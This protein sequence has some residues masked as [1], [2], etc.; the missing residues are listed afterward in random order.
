MLALIAIVVALGRSSARVVYAAGEFAPITT[1][2]PALAFGSVAWGDFDSDGDQ[3][4]LVTGCLAFPCGNSVPFISKVFRNDGAETFTDIAA[5]LVGVYESSVAWGD[6]DRDGDL[7]ILLAGLTTIFSNSAIT[8]IYRN[9]GNGTFTDVGALLPGVGNGSVAWGDYD[10]D[11]DL[12]ILLAGHSS[13]G[14][15]TLSIYRN[16]GAAGF[17]DSG[18]ALGGVAGSAAAW[19][20]YD[21]DGDLDILS[22]GTTT[23]G[24]GGSITRIYR[25]DGNGGFAD[26]GISLP[27]VSSSAV[28]WADY[29]NDGD[30]DLV[31]CG[32]ERDTSARITRIYRNDAG[33]FTDIVAGLIGISDGAVAWGDFDND[34][35]LDL[36]L[37]GSTGAEVTRLYRNDSNHV[38][39][40]VAAGLRDVRY[41]SAAWADANNDARLDLVLMGNYNTEFDHFTKLYLNNAAAVN[42]TPSVP[43]GLAANVSGRTVT[44]N[45]NAASDAETDAPGLTYNVRVG[46]TPGGSQIMSAVADASTGYR[47][48]PQTG[49]VQLGLTAILKGLA[50]GTYYW[51]VQAVDS[52]FAGSP[53]AAEGSFMMAQ[54]ITPTIT[55]TPTSTPTSTPIPPLKLCTLVVA[56]GHLDNDLAQSGTLER[57]IGNFKKGAHSGVCITLWADGPGKNNSI[58]YTCPLRNGTCSD[59]K[60]ETWKTYTM[61]EDSTDYTAFTNFISGTIA[62]T[63]NAVRV[64]VAL[65]GHGSGWSASAFPSLP[66]PWKPQG[67]RMGGMSWDDT[68]DNEVNTPQTR[69]LSTQ[70]MADALYQV[71]RATG[72][73]IDLLYLD[74][75][76][77]G[78]IEVLYELRDS[79]HYVLASPNTDW[80]SFAYHLVL[81]ATKP[82]LDGLALGK[83]WLAQEA[84]VLNAN[85]YPHTLAVYDLSQINAVMSATLPFKAMLQQ[86]LATHRAKIITAATNV[87]RYEGNYNGSI[88]LEDV[89]V[90]FY[91]LGLALHKEFS[92]TKTWV[93]VVQT[94][95]STLKPLVA[96]SRFVTG[97]PWIYRGT[98]WNWNDSLGVSLYLPLPQ[99][100]S[101]SKRFLY[102]ADHLQ[103][104]RDTHW[105]EFLTAYWSEATQRVHPSSVDQ[106]PTC[107]YTR[108]CDLLAKQLPLPFWRVFLPVVP[109]Q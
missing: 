32:I 46:T 78:A 60:N 84:S 77:M 14:R 53:F 52:G 21:G 45:W 83:A 97:T 59:D 54:P 63:P 96:A 107:F 30:L 95:T 36:V 92:D 28:A 79:A 57:L 93:D 99:D 5:D 87:E 9:N 106:L 67:D 23:F 26:S 65:I 100:E 34:G 101:P 98:V 61:T 1:T 8:K 13:S 22:T 49:N 11:G 103:W 69:S 3:D 42:T 56:V 55:P 80:A 7:D 51:S 48:L 62:S 37:T 39:T 105:D 17:K 27:N 81:P 85:Y 88:G 41:S 18:V 15:F 73:K 16:D 50:D 47:R 12:D 64:A 68:P 66:S 40:A 4:V 109:N 31:L 86:M 24:P 104:V 6:Y 94:L 19:G 71:T 89:P 74:A 75:C 29:D 108:E 43:T 76:S 90:D 38:F 70:A 102:T 33:I 82:D 91:S 58:I 20:D 44:L 35:D 25:N 10:N 72:R 2:L